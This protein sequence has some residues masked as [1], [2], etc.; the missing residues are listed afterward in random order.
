MIAHAGLVDHVALL[1]VVLA[2]GATYAWAWEAAARPLRSLASWGVGSIAVLVAL[3][4]PVESVAARTFTGHMLQH[5]L[6][7][8]IAAP[9]LAWATPV[10]TLRRG[11]RARGRRVRAT[12]VERRVGRW[13]RDVGPIVAG[14]AFVGTL[15]ITHLTGVYDL[16]L[17]STAVHHAEHAAYLGSAVLLWSVVGGR[18]RVDGVGRVAAVFGVIAGSALLGVVLISA[19]APLVDTYAARLG[20]GPALDD[21]RIA[22]SLM[23]VGG[24]A[25]TL[26]LAIVALW[27]WAAAEERIARR[28]EQLADRR[29]TEPVG[30]DVR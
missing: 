17:R 14:G 20:A 26:P 30:P 23:W 8:S 9:A 7:I 29:A 15:V 11:L 13:W 22:A 25:T 28:S 5:L 24:M 19:G 12:D 3:S 16:A 18:G 21:Q 6:L 2:A 4:P 27:R 10:T 1:A